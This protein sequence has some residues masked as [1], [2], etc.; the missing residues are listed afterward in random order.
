MQP[1]IK[2][3]P[4][5]LKGERRQKDFLLHIALTSTESSSIHPTK[6]MSDMPQIQALHHLPRP[7]EYSGGHPLQAD[8]LMNWNLQDGK[9]SGEST[10]RNR[11]AN[12]RH[13]M[14]V[15]S[16]TVERRVISEMLSVLGYR[17]TEAEDSGKA[18][19]YFGREPCE[20]VISE[21][22][23]P[24]FNGLQLARCIRK[25]SPQTR[26]LLMTPCCQAEVVDDHEHQKAAH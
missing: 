15:E 3:F 13:V 25:H 14:L 10:S 7:S 9:Q 12:D 11:R 1:K 18:L 22:D 16:G 21:L 6:V 5:L 17:V 24:Q 8:A 20:A 23:I 2:K 26:I 4:F 19:I